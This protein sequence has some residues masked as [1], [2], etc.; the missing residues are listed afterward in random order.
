MSKPLLEL[1]NTTVS[2]GDNTVV[3]DVSWSLNAGETLALVGESGSGK[4]ISALAFQG[5]LPPTA[6]IADQSNFIWYGGD[7]AVDLRS[8]SARQKRRMR[9]CDFGMI[10]QEP[11]SALNPLHTIGRQLRE[12]ITLHEP[13]TGRELDV[14]VIELLHNVELEKLVDRQNAYPHQLSGGQRQRIVIAMAIA[15]RPKLLI[16]D[17]PTT[18]LD[19]TVQQRVLA[20]LRKL[21]AEMGMAILFITHDLGLVQQMAHNVAVMR[22]GEIVEQGTVEQV[23]D[24]PTHD[25][26][27]ALLAARPSG[28]RGAFSHDTAETVLTANDIE[29][30]FPSQTRAPGWRFW[31]KL[32]QQVL[33]S[34]SATVRAGETLGLVG[35]SGSGKSTLAMAMMQA[36]PYQGRVVVM[37][38]ETPECMALAKQMHYVFQDPY[39]ALSPRMTV[40]EIIAEGLKLHEP[41][42]SATDRDERVCEVL[43]QVSLDPAHR[44]RYPHEFS[45]GQR[46]RISLA[47]G[48]VL[49]PAVMILDE[50]TSALDVS[51]QAQVINLLRDLQEREGIAYVFISH[52]LRVVRALA[53]R[54][55]VLKDGKVVEE[56]SV[57]DLFQSPKTDYTQGLIDASHMNDSL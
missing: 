17:E 5:L 16:A 49:R 31:R 4:S 34:V 45:G 20:L 48:L 33:Q 10:F 18:A 13:L 6:T 52:D 57:A 40:A 11:M 46:Q 7:E 2:F 21:Q 19:V 14:R 22:R 51:V 15:N 39:S 12:A 28:E 44:H 53:H 37:G 25:Y 55:M 38:Q 30:S 3:R 24:M 43:G 26:T 23:L 54:V 8:L 42:L 47:R 41:E 29:V 9:G 27:K 36:V 1:K 32:P 50:P 56:Q 35:E